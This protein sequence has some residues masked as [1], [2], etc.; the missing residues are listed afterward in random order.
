MEVIFENSYVRNKKF[1]KHLYRYFYF[2]RP[3]RIFIFIFL[4]L[5]TPWYVHEIIVWGWQGIYS[6]FCLYLILV[7]LQIP[8][9]FHQV[10]SMLKRDKE[11]H[12]CEPTITTIVLEEYIE[13]SVTSGATNQLQYDMIKKCRET[14]H[15]ILLRTK[16]KLVYALP[17][18]A[19][20]KGSADEF[21]VFI[22]NKGIKIR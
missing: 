22:R 19:F 11:V 9:Y 17:K 1:A 14:K 21:K 18:C 15:L 16:A 5:M 10:N 20:T 4:L 8:L 2:Y 12:G 3:I 13:F 7:L 6:A